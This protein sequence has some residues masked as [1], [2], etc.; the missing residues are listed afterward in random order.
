MSRITVRDLIVNACDEARL[1]NR[2]QPIP[3]NI[4]LSA[5]MLLQKRLSQ[6]SNTNLLS[7]TRNEIDF[8]P[9]GKTELIIGSITYNEDRPKDVEVQDKYA[10]RHWSDVGFVYF[11][12]VKKFYTCSGSAYGVVWSEDTTAMFEDYFE[13]V[14]DIEVDNI[15]E[16]VRVYISTKNSTVNRWS[17]LNFVSYEDF[18]SWKEEADVYSVLPLDDDHV[19]LMLKRRISERYDIKLMYNE[20]FEFNQDSELNVP[21]QF[22]ALF[23]AGL[24][25]DLALQY[26]RLSDNTVAMLK[27]RLDEL[28]ENVRRSSSV[29]KFIK[30]EI[31]RDS[32]TYTDFIT[33]RF[34]GV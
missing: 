5:Y 32:I 8:D 17:E 7:F 15:Q 13:C 27:S 11:K 14:P 34:L 3:G 28:E 18:Y 6:Y 2:S 19:K 30:R 25:Y 24:V 23:T 20:A 9:E 31:T 21:R 1:V 4:F 33:G 12:D 16:V 26:P 29:N 22:V 10:E